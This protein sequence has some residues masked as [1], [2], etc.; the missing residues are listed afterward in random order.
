MSKQKP[1]KVIAGAPDR[2][3][4]I[5]DIEIPAYVLEN[6]TRVLSRRGFLGAIGRSERAGGQ[7]TRG[8]AQDLPDFL[9]ASNLTPFVH[10]E[11]TVRTTPILFQTPGGQRGYGYRAEL[12]PEVCDVFLKAREAGALLPQQEHIAARAE[13]LIRGLATVGIIGLVDEATGY[14]EIRDREALNR[15]LD[16][17]LLAERAKWAKRFPDDFYKEIFR[18]RQWLWQ[19]M[20]VN[21][22]SVVGRYT[23]DCVWDR[24]APGLREE[25]ERLNPKNET[26]S[27]RARH[28]QWLTSDVGHPALQK[29]LSGVM[30]LMRAS[31]T[32]D[33][34]RRLLQRAYPKVNTTF[35]MPLDD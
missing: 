2:P 25:L 33:H 14:Q 7:T 21:R 11:F 35:E 10:A 22:P 13:I 29:H 30:A 27:R 1:L 9:A 6:E 31:S 34:F 24:L 8:R 4:V 32:W 5:G 28:H 12:L 17:Y 19:G 26:G 20:Q 18:L 16:K 3:L 23:N 15:I